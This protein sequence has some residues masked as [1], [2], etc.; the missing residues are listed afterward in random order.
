[1]AALPDQ[2]QHGSQSVV[3]IHDKGAIRAGDM[4]ILVT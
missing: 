2:K 4:E 3:T 1:M